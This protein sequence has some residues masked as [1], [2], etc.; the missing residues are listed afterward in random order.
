MLKI[1]TLFQTENLLV[2]HIHI[3]LTEVFTRKQH[4]Q[5]IVVFVLQRD[6]TGVLV[7]EF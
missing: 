1:Y 7:G 6:W 2:P 3:K 5:H 4:K